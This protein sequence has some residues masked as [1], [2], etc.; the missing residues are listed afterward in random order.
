MPAAI[1]A[2]RPGRIV[3]VNKLADGRAG[4]EAEFHFLAAVVEVVIA[5]PFARNDRIVRVA[6]ARV[7]GSEV[8]DHEDASRR[9]RGW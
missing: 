9:E 3:V 5:L 4:A 1:G 8:L 2:I 6:V 7:E